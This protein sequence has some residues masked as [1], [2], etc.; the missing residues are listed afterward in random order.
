M[1]FGQVHIGISDV[2]ICDRSGLQHFLTSRSETERSIFLV[3]AIRTADEDIRIRASAF[4]LAEKL[5]GLLSELNGIQKFDIPLGD[6]EFS[7]RGV[8]MAGLFTISL[9]AH[10]EL[11]R[12]T[13]SKD[14]IALFFCHLLSDIDSRLSLEGI[15]LS[16]LLTKFPVLG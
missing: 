15:P 7:I 3:L 12:F 6:G 1:S 14:Q 10:Q 13:Y 2:H 11:S 4:A 9:T 8:N 16:R 5:L